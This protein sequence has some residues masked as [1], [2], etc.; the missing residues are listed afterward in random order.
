MPKLRFI[1]PLIFFA[2]CANNIIPLPAADQKQINSDTK[3]VD[4]TSGG[5]RLLVY[6]FGSPP[7]RVGDQQIRGSGLRAFLI[8]GKTGTSTQY[9]WTEAGLDVEID[10]S[11]AAAGYIYFVEHT[12]DPRAET[13]DAPLVRRNIR[14]RDGVFTESDEF[15]LRAEP[16]DT[17]RISDLVSQVKHAI[18]TEGDFDVPM[19]HLRNIGVARPEVILAAFKNI[20]ADGAAGES[21]SQYVSEVEMAADIRN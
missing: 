21:L 10:Y 1:L 15:L 6:G 8:S 4:V 7:V 2:G 14:F 20:T 5:C 16:G 11:R 17:A 3:I 18:A 9:C 12:Y 19:A 13:D